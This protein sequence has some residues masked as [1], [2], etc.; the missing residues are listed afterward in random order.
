MWK[1][2]D[3]R[4]FEF[5]P[6]IRKSVGLS[7]SNF[8]GLFAEICRRI[9]YYIKTVYIQLNITL[10]ILAEYCETTLNWTEE[11]QYSLGYSNFNSLIFQVWPMYS[12]TYTIPTPAYRV[13]HYKILQFNTRLRVKVFSGKKFCSSKTSYIF[14]Y[15]GYC[16]TFSHPLM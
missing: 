15:L 3:A 4:G 12:N 11:S 5:K 9:L 16:L 7:F 1:H 2:S 10:S 14:R 13:F 8:Q 6:W